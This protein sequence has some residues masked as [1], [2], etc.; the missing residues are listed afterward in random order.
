[1]GYSAERRMVSMSMS[2]R[3]RWASA[4]M[5]CSAGIRRRH[6]PRVVAY[7]HTISARE[8]ADADERHTAGDS[9]PLC[10]FMT[11]R[12]VISRPTPT[13]VSHRGLE[14]HRAPPVLLE[15]G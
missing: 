6:R 13:L 5:R 4:L 14:R 10:A 1:M 11:S 9:S 7:H 15:A 3:C 12:H 8:T 2:I